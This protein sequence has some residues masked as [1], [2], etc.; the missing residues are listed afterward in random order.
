[1][2]ELQ[3]QKFHSCQERTGLWGTGIMSIVSTSRSEMLFCSPH[4]DYRVWV[5]IILPIWAFFLPTFIKKA[6]P[7]THVMVFFSP[8]SVCLKTLKT[9][10]CKNPRRSQQ[11]LKCSNQPWLKSTSSFSHFP[12]ILMLW[13]EHYLKLLTNI[14]MISCFVLL[15]YWNIFVLFHKTLHSFRS[16]EINSH[17]R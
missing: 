6:F 3:K 7:P 1:M 2:G 10:V 11:F 12:P 15:P 8:T 13:C 17:R 14:W 4:Y 16:S 5:T 9:I